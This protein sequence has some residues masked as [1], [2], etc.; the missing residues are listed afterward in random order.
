VSDFGLAKLLDLEGGQTHTGAA[1]GT[2]PYMS[3][4]QARGDSKAI[5]PLADVYGLGAILYELL[6]GRPPFLSATKQKTLEQVQT[7][8]PVPPTRIN[9]G[10]ARDLEAVCLKCLEKAPARRYP[11]AGALADDLGRWLRGEPTLAR[12]LQWPGRAWRYVRVHKGTASALAIWV[13]GLAIWVYLDPERPRQE[14]AYDLRH[15]RQ[16]TFVPIAG[17]PSYSRWCLGEDTSGTYLAADGAFSI[18]CSE[19]AL[20]EIVPDPQQDAYEIRVDVR[21]ERAGDAGE[22][23]VYLGH[24]IHS[25]TNGQPLHYFEVP[26][27][28]V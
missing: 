4:E 17:K 3:P 13:T 11:S 22:V 6:T 20:L 27:I 26:S 14:A 1:L 21:H 7:Q 24:R 28:G 18:Y 19:L 25:T 12:P 16:V 9:P 10:L 23:G 8:E 2:P 15:H 5:G